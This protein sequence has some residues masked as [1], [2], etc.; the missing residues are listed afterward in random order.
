MRQKMSKKNVEKLA[1]ELNLPIEQI[2]VRGGTN[3]RKDLCLE[4]GSIICLFQNG[5][6]VKTDAKWYKE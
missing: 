1:K 3:H 5:E 2:L 4:D 6:L